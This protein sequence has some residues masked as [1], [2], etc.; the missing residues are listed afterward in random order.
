MLVLKHW[1]SKKLGIKFW[2]SDVG[3]QVLVVLQCWYSNAGTQMMVVK[4]WYPNAGTQMMV[5]K[6]WCSNDGR[7]MFVMKLDWATKFN[8]FENKNV[9]Q[10][11]GNIISNETHDPAVVKR[12]IGEAESNAAH[13]RSFLK[14]I[15][16]LRRGNEKARLELLPK[17][18]TKMVKSDSENA[19]DKEPAPSP[20]QAPSTFGSGTQRPLA[21]YLQAKNGDKDSNKDSNTSDVTNTTMKVEKTEG[22]R[23]P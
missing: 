1:Y 9:L 22:V 15:S 5:L 10:A 16:S 7:H 8:P 13:M 23:I 20:Q 4:C 3:A 19:S 17:Q 6:C 21:S 14:T 12:M 11:V 18:P 2:Y